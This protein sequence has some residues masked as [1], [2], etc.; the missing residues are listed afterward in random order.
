[1]GKEL[2]DARKFILEQQAFITRRL[3]E[4]ERIARELARLSAAWI[5]GSSPALEKKLARLERRLEGIRDHLEENIS[6]G[7]HE[8]L[9]LLVRYAADIMAVGLPVENA[10]LLT[11]VEEVRTCAV[12]LETPPASR[13]ACL[14]CERNVKDAIDLVWSLF[15][16]NTATLEAIRRLIGDSVGTENNQTERK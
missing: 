3:D 8:L 9:P 16:E 7:E 14:S 2:A 15:Q 1:V 13:E 6:L 4:R 11:A 10:R 5:P 12:K